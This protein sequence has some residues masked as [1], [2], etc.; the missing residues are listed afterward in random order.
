MSTPLKDLFQIWRQMLVVNIASAMAYRAQTV[1]WLLGGIGPL[2]TMLI[3]V[4]LSR[5]RTIAGYSAS[6]FF[7]YFLAIYL[8]RQLTSM[9]V[10]FTVNADIL[11]GDLSMHLLKPVPPAWH[12]M[13]NNIGQL[14][15]R[16]PIVIF[17][18]S[19]LASAFPTGIEITFFHLIA[20]M[21]SVL[22]AWIIMFNIYY[23]V[24]LLA[25]WISNAAAF[26]P[27]LWSIYTLLGGV[28][29]PIDLMPEPARTV[30]A[31]LPFA[32]AL[33]TPA[34]ILIGKFDTSGVFSGLGMQLFWAVASI[35]AR[36]FLWS[37][38]VKRYSAAG[39]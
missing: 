17:V 15:V 38:G 7:S 26:D 9:W 29:V 2:A 16:G 3:W 12:Y 18:F 39:A 11:R 22:L 31:S 4:G 24:G 27:L 25:F 23:G 36:K 28:L 14:A 6:D 34:K 8:V 21:I 37:K 19:V 10:L 30:V 1:I 33:D 32:A 13:A 20:F 5:E 35:A